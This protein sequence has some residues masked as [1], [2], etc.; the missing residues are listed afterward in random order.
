[1]SGCSAQRKWSS[2]RRWRHNMLLHAS[3]VLWSRDAPFRRVQ[4]DF[5]PLGRPQFTGT[6]RIPERSP[7]RKAASVVGWPLE[8]IDSAGGSHCQR[9]LALLTQ[10]VVFGFRTGYRSPQIGDWVVARQ[11]VFRLRMRRSRPT[12]CFDR[13]AVS[14]VPLA[15]ILSKA[16]KASG[17]SRCCGGDWA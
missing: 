2:L 4:Y 11:G 10:R 13:R 12:H 16:M 17:A 8:P 5:R 7:V 9:R 6:P 1:M 15:F 14:W 3:F